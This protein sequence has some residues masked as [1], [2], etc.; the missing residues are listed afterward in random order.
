[1]GIAPDTSDTATCGITRAGVDKDVVFEFDVADCEMFTLGAVDIE[2]FKFDEFDFK[3]LAL[4][5][6][7]DIAM[8]ERFEIKFEN[9]A[10]NASAPDTLAERTSRAVFAAVIVDVTALAGLN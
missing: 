1:M 3:V 10:P 7:G 4:V 9:L 8:I 5:E 6:T 2:D